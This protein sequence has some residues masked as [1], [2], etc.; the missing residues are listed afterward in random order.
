MLEKIDSIFAKWKA[1][2]DLPDWLVDSHILEVSAVLLILLI[3]YLMYKSAR[4]VE[5]SD[6]GKVIVKYHSPLTWVSRARNNLAKNRANYSPKQKQFLSSM[7]R[8]RNFME[9]LLVLLLGSILTAAGAF[10][11]YMEPVSILERYPAGL[12]I[13][14]LLFIAYGIYI[15]RTANAG[16]PFLPD[17]ET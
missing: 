7:Y 12:L 1:N 14:G 9:A 6:S 2:T 4:T 13:V 5:V 10:L 16:N 11:V 8:G 3:L 15:V 17:D